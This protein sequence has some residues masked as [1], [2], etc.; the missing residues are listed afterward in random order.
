[1]GAGADTRLFVIEISGERGRNRTFNLVI[2][3]HL[4]C[5]LSY[6]PG[7][8]IHRLGADPERA[9]SALASAHCSIADWC[10][11]MVWGGLWGRAGPA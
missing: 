4:L 7:R 3:S 2:K 10:V 1:M 11:R 5:Q 8:E 9:E 6:A